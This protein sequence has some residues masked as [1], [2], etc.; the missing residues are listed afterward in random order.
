LKSNLKEQVADLQKELQEVKSNTNKL[1]VKVSAYL[2]PRLQ[3]MDKELV[4]LRDKFW[5]DPS[6]SLII[7][8]EKRIK[9][10]EAKH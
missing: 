4:Y 2:V 3:K 10:L 1:Q 7:G 5:Q 9:Q 8:L 6:L